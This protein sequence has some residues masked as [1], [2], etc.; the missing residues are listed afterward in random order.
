M[1]VSD[2]LPLCIDLDETLLKTDTLLESVLLLL[3]SKPFHALL[4]PLWLLK[5]KA[6]LKQQIAQRVTLDVAFLPY[7]PELLA[8]LI[9]QHRTGRKIILATAADIRIAHQIAKHLGLFSKVLASNTT[10]N[11]SG[12]RKLE[13]INH[14]LGPG[15]FV[16]AGNAKVDLP[17]W[18][19]A[20]NAI[21]VNAPNRLVRSV[22]KVANVRFIFTDR[23]HPVQAFFRA[24]RA[25]QWVKNALV[26]VPLIAGHQVTHPVPLIHAVLAFVAFSFCSSSAYVLNDL[27]DL[28]TD[29][30]HPRKKHRPFASG[31]LP[32]K[33]GFF[34][35]PLLL[36]A[37]L[38]LSLLLPFGLTITL[39]AYYVSTLGYSFYLKR[40][41]LVDVILLALLYTIRI[42]GGGVATNIYISNW[43]L[44]FSMFF[45]LSLALLKRFSELQGLVRQE[46]ELNKSRGYS[47]VDIEQLASMGSA[48]GYITA[49]VLGLYIN[50]EDVKLLYAHPNILWLTCPLIL[51]WVSRAWLIARRGR[52]DDDPVVFA[53]K[54]RA[55]YA[56]G[57]LAAI[58]IVF[59]IG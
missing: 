49:L 24:I 4:L 7:Q 29:R 51:Y 30:R 45:F 42:I 53:I 28:E 50:S 37:G 9:E 27:L 34:M 52:M 18:E 22:S 20:K 58:I 5:G 54:D 35:I 31:D 48:S 44:V 10:L 6:H 25:Y 39:G 38:A 55:S 43:L 2:E 12:F 56:V 13:M 46:Q 15:R 14:H 17:I 1:P 33:A 8:Y 23:K 59:A 40:V 26:F 3:K 47:A 16:Y 57:V 36:F 19:S 41:V 11:L 21:I 32:F